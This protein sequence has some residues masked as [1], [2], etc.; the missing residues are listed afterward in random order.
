MKVNGALVLFKSGSILQ[1]R[2]KTFNESF[3]TSTE[4]KGGILRKPEPPSGLKHNST[5]ESVLMTWMNLEPIIQSEVNQKERNKYRVLMH[6]YM[7]S[8]KM[9]LMN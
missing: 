5:F 8:R 6:I 4:F 3:I 9:A 1:K 7:E 2:E